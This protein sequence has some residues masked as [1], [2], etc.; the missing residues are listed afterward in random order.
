M[1]LSSFSMI[2]VL[3]GINIGSLFTW[4]LIIYYFSVLIERVIKKDFSG[5]I[6]QKTVICFIL[7]LCLFLSYLLNMNEAE[8][9]KTISLIVYLVSPVFMDIDLS[10]SKSASISIIC[11]TISFFLSN[12][13]AYSFIYILKDRAVDFLSL[14]LPKWLKYYQMNNGS[15]RFSGLND[16]PNYNSFLSLFLAS[17]CLLSTVDK[18]A[19]KQKWILVLLA[20]IIQPFAILSMSK[21]YLIMA[22]VFTIY[23]IAIVF[24]VFKINSIYIPISLLIISLLS[25]PFVLIFRSTILRIFSGD[26]RTGFISSIT[27]GRS[28][29]FT[30]YLS[31]FSSDPLRLLIGHGAHAKSIEFLNDMHNTILRIIWDCGL[32]GAIPYCAYFIVFMRFK[33]SNLNNTILKIGPLF[34]LAIYTFALDLASNHIV[35]FSVYIFSIIDVLHVKER[36]TELF[37][38]IEI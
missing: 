11:L 29:L 30:A 15:F 31:E 26:T 9:S 12:L 10:F 18:T 34:L 37:Y 19:K 28:D 7:C 33:P 14:V 5:I 24:I 2:M 4:L 22:V 21:T 3:R 23:L 38:E 32:I 13:F 27:T 25:I 6:S 17:M 35:F 1:L 16:D 8:F 20:T 36:I